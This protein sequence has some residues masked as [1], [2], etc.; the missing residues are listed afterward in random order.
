MTNF[1]DVKI[2]LPPRKH[3][4][5]VPDGYLSMGQCASRLGVSIATARAMVLAECGE[6]VFRAR[7]KYFVK[8]EAF[9]VMK[10]SHTGVKPDGTN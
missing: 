3:R 5:V 9:T 8:E 2:P 6:S 1:S 10:D 4:K 7:K